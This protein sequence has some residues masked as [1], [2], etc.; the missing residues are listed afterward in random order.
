MICGA[1][2]NKLSELAR[3]QRVKVAK[4]GFLTIGDLFR[5]V[6]VLKVEGAPVSHKNAGE[7]ISKLCVQCLRRSGDPNEF[8]RSAA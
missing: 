5:T 4:A 6:H 7:L 8:I 1:V 2:A 3:S